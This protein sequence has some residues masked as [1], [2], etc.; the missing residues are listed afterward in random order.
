MKVYIFQYI[1][2]IPEKASNTCLF[3]SIQ[4]LNLHSTL[5]IELP[6]S[7]LTLINTYYY[8][9]YRKQNITKH[10]LIMMIVYD[11]YEDSSGKKVLHLPLSI[12]QKLIYFAYF[13]REFKLR[14]LCVI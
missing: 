9:V 6:L 1:L 5:S 7:S 10:N 13:K 14:K 11:E 3:H 2:I 4:I 12:R 8:T